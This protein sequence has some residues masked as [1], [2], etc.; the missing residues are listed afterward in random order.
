[1]RLRRTFSPHDNKL[2]EGNL[3]LVDGIGHGNADPQAV[4]RFGAV[5]RR[6][7]LAVGELQPLQDDGVG[8]GDDVLRLAQVVLQDL[9]L[10]LAQVPRFV[11]AR[12]A[13]ARGEGEVAERRDGELGAAVGKMVGRPDHGEGSW[14]ERKPGRRGLCL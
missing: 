8:A 4:G 12:A 14:E 7:V 11:R 3:T 2:E 6:Q 1:M 10:V 9:A 5:G 13:V